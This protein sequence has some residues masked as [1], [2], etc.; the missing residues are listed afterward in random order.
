MSSL[1]ALDVAATSDDVAFWRLHVLALV[2]ES[3]AQDVATRQLDAEHTARCVL[4]ARDLD[5]ARYQ[6]NF[7]T[8]SQKKKHTGL[9]YLQTSTIASAQDRESATIRR[10]K[11]FQTA[12]T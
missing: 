10:S 4:P 7:E 12:T 8:A 3:G 11:S 5:C 1:V 2:I 6:P 9:I